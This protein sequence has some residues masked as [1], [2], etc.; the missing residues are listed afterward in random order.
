MSDILI[1]LGF[2]AFMGI[3]CAACVVAGAWVAFR[4]RREPGTGQG[5]IKDPKGDV[6]T[7][8]DDSELADFPGTEEPSKE[9]Q[10]LLNRA[11]QFL[12]KF[13]V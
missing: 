13:N 3:L 2:A 4:I 1:T 11:N 8:P 6:F 5:F 7:I 12:E 9:E 10:H